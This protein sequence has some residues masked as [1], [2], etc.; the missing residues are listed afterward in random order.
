M[1]N[2][3]R[4]VAVFLAGDEGSCPVNW[5]LVLPPSWDGDAERRS[6]TKVPG[7]ERAQAAWRYILDALDEIIDE[8]GVAPAPV[9]VDI[10]NDP[11]MGA[12][13]RGLEERG[14]RYLVGVSALAPA[15]PAGRTEPV[16]GAPRPPTVGQL[17]AMA[18]KRGRTT[19]SWR[20]GDAGKLSSSQFVVATVPGSVG[21]DEIRQGRALVRSRQVLA[22]WPWGQDR[23]RALW[24]TNLGATGI[25]EMTT[26]LRARQQ[27]TDDADLLIEEIGIRHFEGRSYQGWHHH[28]TLASIAHG[29]RLVRRLDEQQF[30][31]EWLRPYA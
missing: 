1:L 17:A 13:L 19:L 23:P 31:A 26:L 20:D 22:D 5:R 12:L 3:Q 11:G 9:V 14:L 30:V 6:K 16:V 10:G 21:P 15:V 7:H 24:L 8:W 18:A 25:V 28:V 4:A 2:C 27:V 29:Y